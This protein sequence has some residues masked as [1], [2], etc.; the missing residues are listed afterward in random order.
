MAEYGEGAEW[1]GRERHETARD[2]DGEKEYARRPRAIDI[3]I[4]AACERA[5]PFVEDALKRG[6]SYFQSELNTGGGARRIDLEFA[7][8][9]G[10]FYRR[11]LGLM[12]LMQKH[13]PRPTLP[14][15]FAVSTGVNR[16]VVAFEGIRT[17]ESGIR[18]QRVMANIGR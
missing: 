1:P 7:N 15:Y 11:C 2:N 12:K 8:G 16:Y 18:A 3:A 13:V 17:M 6:F 10:Q 14:E 9:K 4:D 5:K